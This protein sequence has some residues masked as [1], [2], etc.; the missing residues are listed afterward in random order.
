MRLCWGIA[1]LLLT[2]IRAY[3]LLEDAPQT[4]RPEHNPPLSPIAAQK[5]D[6]WTNGQ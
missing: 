3:T 5:A 2:P 4:Q 6:Y 1:S